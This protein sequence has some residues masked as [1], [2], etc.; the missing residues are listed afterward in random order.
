MKAWEVLDKDGKD[1]FSEFVFADT[2]SDAILKSEAY[3]ESKRY[4]DLTAVR[5]RVLDDK[6]SLTENERIVILIREG[7]VFDI[8]GRQISEDNLELALL[9]G[10]L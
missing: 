1:E 9:N 2:R 3:Q 6:E 7:W 5:L 4:L 8:E 10:W